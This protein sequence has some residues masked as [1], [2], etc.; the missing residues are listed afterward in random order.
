MSMMAMQELLICLHENCKIV[1]QLSV[2][3]RGKTEIIGSDFN[4]DVSRIRW[5]V[6]RTT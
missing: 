4:I 2:L 6:R 3:S 1:A 5:E